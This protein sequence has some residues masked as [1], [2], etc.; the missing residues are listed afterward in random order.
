MFIGTDAGLVTLLGVLALSLGGAVTDLLWGRIFNWMNGLG[1]VSGLAASA[2]LAGWAG[3]LSSALAV[4]A[5]LLLYGWIF[6]VGAMGG[7][8][9]KFLMALGAW[10]GWHFILQ[11]AF[12]GII[13]GGALALSTLLFKRRLGDF[14][15][16]LHRFVLTLV[17]KELKAEPLRIDH[18]QT[19]PFGI[20]IAL[21][22]AWVALANPFV[23]LGAHL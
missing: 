4:L 17:L 7:G 6:W 3:L 8:D 9:V 16:R 2:F 1:V 10:G 21:A 19:M 12:L 5:A 20:A 15:G 11:V 23:W 22:A 13:V 18:R 14:L